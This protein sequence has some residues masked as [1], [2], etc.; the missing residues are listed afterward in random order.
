MVAVY[1]KAWK[2]GDGTDLIKAR[3]NH[4]RNSQ[5]VNLKKR[6]NSEDKQQIHNREDV[7]KNL[8]RSQERLKDGSLIVQRS[9]LSL[10]KRQKQIDKK[11][12]SKR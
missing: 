10:E 4:I 2:A 7:L 9:V 12:Q 8:P 3:Y 5:T 6:I 1:E 11:T